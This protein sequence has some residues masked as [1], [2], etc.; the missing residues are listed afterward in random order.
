MNSIWVLSMCAV[1]EGGGDVILA[2]LFATKQEAKDRV[3]YYSKTAES[4]GCVDWAIHEE[5]NPLEGIGPNDLITGS[6][7][8]EIF[9][10]LYEENENRGLS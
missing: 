4:W 10:R 1:S 9:D 3:E 5:Q 7:L 6:Q 8:S 2:E